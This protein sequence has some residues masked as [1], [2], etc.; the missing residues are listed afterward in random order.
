[1]IFIIIV[2]IAI[3][4]VDLVTKYWAAS[5]LAGGESISII[6]DI[7]H[8]RYT[9]NTGGAF[10][11]FNSMPW[12]FFV[13]IPLIVLLIIFFLVK[14]KPKHWVARTAAA[15]IL[16][17]AAGN[18]FDRIVFGYV[19]DFIYLKA[20]NFAIFNVADM[21]I[22]VGAILLGIYILFLDK[23]PDAIFP[24]NKKPTETKQGE[25]DDGNA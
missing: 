2:A 6:G 11:M 7:L 1:M 8:F 14:Y 25:T 17:G 20:I 15:L 4:A 13:L 16:S 23:G 9:T 3:F 18:M 5:A 10:S 24:E 21:A 12:L 22:V 19:R